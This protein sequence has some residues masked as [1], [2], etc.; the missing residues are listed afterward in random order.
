MIYDLNEWAEKTIQRQLDNPDHYSLAHQ[1]EDIKG[2][3]YLSEK[4][5]ITGYMSGPVSMHNGIPVT[6]QSVRF[7]SLEEF[8]NKYSDGT[9]V[10]LYEVTFYPNIPIYEIYDDKNG[11]VNLSDPEITENMGTWK[12]RYGIIET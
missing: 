3:K 7:S 10:F 11:I 8:V 4:M 5:A 2:A 12:I 1:F 9:K 6:A